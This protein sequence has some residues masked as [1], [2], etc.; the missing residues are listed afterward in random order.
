MKY[1]DTLPLSGLPCISKKLRHVLIKSN[2]TNI[3]KIV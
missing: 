1:Y 3:L 2:T